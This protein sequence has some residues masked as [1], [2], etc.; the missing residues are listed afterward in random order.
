RRAAE[1]VPTQPLNGCALIGND[2]C[3]PYQ[4]NRHEA[5]KKNGKD[6]ND[7]NIGLVN[8]KAEDAAKPSH[9]KGP[10]STGKSAHIWISEAESSTPRAAFADKRSEERRVGKEC[11]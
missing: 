2:L 9:D 4:S 7:N 3:L 11:G 5:H 6:E 8:R 10:P 1:L